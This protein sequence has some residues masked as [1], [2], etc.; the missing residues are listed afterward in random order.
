MS[1][2]QWVLQLPISW[3]FELTDNINYL[4]SLFILND[5]INFSRS[6]YKHYNA[7][8]YITNTDYYR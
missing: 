8:K 7:L 4:M 5:I 1:T 3:C 6:K 2:P